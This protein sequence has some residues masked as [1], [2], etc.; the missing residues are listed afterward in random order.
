MRRQGIS[1]LVRLRKHTNY[2]FFRS[3]LMWTIIYS[4]VNNNKINNNHNK[5]NNNKYNSYNNNRDSRQS[6]NRRQ[7]W[8]RQRFLGPWPLPSRA[9]LT[10]PPYLERYGGGGGRRHAAERRRR[11]ETAAA[12]PPPQTAASAGD[13]R[14]PAVSG[15]RRDDLGVRRRMSALQTLVC[16]CARARSCPIAP[17]RFLPLLRSPSHSVSVCPSVRV[18]R[19]SVRSPEC[20]SASPTDITPASRVRRRPPSPAMSVLHAPSNCERTPLNTDTDAFSCM[21]TSTRSS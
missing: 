13:A 21:V 18:S 5:N 2:H 17:Y 4:F 15:R 1:Y 10:R 12:P 8:R 16:V 3:T 20:T 19:L 9:T 6:Q 7:R 14:R 11:A